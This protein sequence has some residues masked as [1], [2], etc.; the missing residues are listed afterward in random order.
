MVGVRDKILNSLFEFPG[1]WFIDLNEWVQKYH[2]A[3]DTKSLLIIKFETWYK[4]LTSVAGREASE[5]GDIQHNKRT[6]E[7]QGYRSQETCTWHLTSSLALIAQ[8]LL[9]WKPKENYNWETTWQNY[10]ILEN[11]LQVQLLE[12]SAEK[13]KPTIEELLPLG[14]F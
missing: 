8:N 11:N 10:G 1:F 7:R 3:C 9:H 6:E 5:V 2:V 4:G 14:L 12:A 13:Q